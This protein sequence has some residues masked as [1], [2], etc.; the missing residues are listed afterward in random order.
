VNVLKVDSRTIDLALASDFSDFEDALQ[1]SCALDHGLT[2]LITRNV[3]DYKKASISVITP[4]IFLKQ[5]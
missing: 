2:V 5:F 3:K 1:Y 4:E